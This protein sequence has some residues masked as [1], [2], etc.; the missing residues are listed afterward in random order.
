MLR[1]LYTRFAY[2]SIPREVGRGPLA[3]RR[4]GWPRPPGET[5]VSRAGGGMFGS[6]KRFN[7][8]V[9]C[10]RSLYVR[11]AAAKTQ[12]VNK[13][14]PKLIKYDIERKLVDNMYNTTFRIA[15][16]SLL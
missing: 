9:P 2:A 16:T 10:S 12:T 8:L 7:Y 13:R 3:R 6:C 14:D 5:V 4:N 1:A 15:S 11:D